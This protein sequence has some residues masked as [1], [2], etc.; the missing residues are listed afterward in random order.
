MSSQGGSVLFAAAGCARNTSSRHF[1]K[2]VAP[3]VQSV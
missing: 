3:S 1:S 2:P